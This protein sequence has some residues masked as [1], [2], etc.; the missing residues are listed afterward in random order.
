MINTGN[1]TKNVYMGEVFVIFVCDF[2]HSEWFASGALFDSGLSSL[3][4]LFLKDDM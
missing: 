4:C 2:F 1:G 3:C